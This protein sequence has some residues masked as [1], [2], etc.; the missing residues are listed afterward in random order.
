MLGPVLRGIISKNFDKMY[1][2]RVGS[3]KV[4]AVVR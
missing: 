2:A 3:S 1:K 4:K